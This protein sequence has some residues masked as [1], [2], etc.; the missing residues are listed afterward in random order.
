G[1]RVRQRLSEPA[2]P[3][4][5]ERVRRIVSGHWSSRYG[6]TETHRESLRIA[7]TEWAETSARLR[8]LLEVDLVEIERAM[9]AAGAPWTPGRRIP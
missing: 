5:R 7:S 4:I 9:E 2:K 8:A 6:P 1:D 3:S